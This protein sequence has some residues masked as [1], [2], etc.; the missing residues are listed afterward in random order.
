MPYL[1]GARTTESDLNRDWVLTHELFHFTFPS[2]PDKHLWIE[3]GISTYAE[4]IARAAVGLS[5]REQVWRDMI[6]DM[7]QGLPAEGDRGLDQTH[8]WGRTYWGGALF[9]FLADIGIRKATANRRSLR[10]AL[11]GIN[12]A[13]GNITTEWPLSRALEAADHATGTSVLSDLYQNMGSSYSPVD[14]A[15]LWKELGVSTSGGQVRFDD[16]AP[17]SDSGGSNNCPGRSKRH[18]QSRCQGQRAV[19]MLLA[20]ASHH[21]GK[22]RQNAWRQNRD[23]TGCKTQPI[24]PHRQSPLRRNARSSSESVTPMDRVTSRAC[25]SVHALPGGTLIGTLDFPLVVGPGGRMS[26]IRIIGEDDAVDEL[27]R[28]YET[29][30]SNRGQVANILKAHSVHPAVMGAHLAL[31]RELM[32]GPSE[33]SRADRELVAVAVSS[34]NGCHY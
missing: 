11:Q 8:T 10:D 32:F 5:T 34:T 29:V 31:Y 20:G 23:R 21:D 7:P 24:S 25:R 13:G 33:L 19:T 4:P 14:L 6:R 28:A 18:D 12:R 30:K 27:Q 16:A 1:A 26:W 2:V 17:Q 3:E 9:C 22:H 15:G